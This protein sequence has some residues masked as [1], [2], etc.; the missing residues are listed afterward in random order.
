M[1][2]NLPHL[3]IEIIVQGRENGYSLDKKVDTTIS[4]IVIGQKNG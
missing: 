1:G 4:S 2:V 3:I